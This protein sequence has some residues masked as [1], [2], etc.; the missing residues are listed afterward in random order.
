MDDNDANMRRRVGI[1]TVQDGLH[2]AAQRNIFRM[3]LCG[4]WRRSHAEKQRNEQMDCR[5]S[6]GFLH[7]P[8]PPLVLP[9]SRSDRSVVTASFASK[10]QSDRKIS[11]P[12][13]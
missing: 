12:V 6:C 1:G 3:A 13:E 4:C 7:D 8:I 2:S 11:P 5:K 10:C 9:L